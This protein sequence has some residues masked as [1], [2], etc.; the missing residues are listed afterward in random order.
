MGL[1][2]SKTKQR[3]SELYNNN[4]DEILDNMRNLNKNEQLPSPPT[5][6]NPVVKLIIK[7]TQM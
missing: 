7:N 4:I 6:S 2:F 1:F 5:Y 3:K